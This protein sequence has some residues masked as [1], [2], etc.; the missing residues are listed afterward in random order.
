[1]PV[2]V[3]TCTTRSH[4]EIALALANTILAH[5]EQVIQRIVDKDCNS[6][7]TIATIAISS[8]YGVSSGYR[9]RSNRSR[10][11][12]VGQT[13]GWRPYI[14]R[15]ATRPG[16]IQNNRVILTFYRRMVHYDHRNS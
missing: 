13:I 14:A 12:R 3:A 7:E 5:D 4:E 2:E 9:R 6:C 11:E 1:M 16:S 8:R 15:R 10:T